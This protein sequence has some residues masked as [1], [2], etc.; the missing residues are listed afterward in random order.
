M[1]FCAKDD[2]AFCDIDNG[3]CGNYKTLQIRKS[4][5]LR[6]QNDENKNGK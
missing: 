1:K 4:A 6:L 3:T 2:N 5:K